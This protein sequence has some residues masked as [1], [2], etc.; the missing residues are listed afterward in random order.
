MNA[1][2]I[3]AGWL[4]QVA[5]R[6]DPQ[7]RLLRAWPLKG[8]ISAQMT[9]LEIQSANGGTRKVIV[10]RPPPWTLERNPRAA[11]DEFRV[12]QL[13]KSLGVA[14]PE[15][16]YVDESRELLSEPYLVIEFIEG[17]PQYTP[18]D[19]KDFVEQMARQLAQI[20]QIKASNPALRSLRQQANRLSDK[21]SQRPGKV[22]A[23]MD[24]GRIRDTLEAV[25]PLPQQNEHVLLHGD[26]WPGNI[27]WEDGQI[28]AV[29]DWEEAEVGDPLADVAISRLDILWLCSREAMHDFTRQYRRLNP[30]DFT[31]LPYWDLIAALRPAGYI[32]EWARWWPEVGRPDIS[33]DSM[34]K[35]HAWFVRQ[36]YEELDRK[37]GKTIDER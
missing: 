7:S 4:E 35:D 1:E 2:L 23:S 30:V 36:A 5:Q 10:R 20:H 17:Q 33:E 28:V 15:P 34:R 26:F 37:S 25:W 32:G 8:G 16:C 22:D 9:A 14:I 21:L 11:R 29:V 13:V 27:L 18:P 3:E 31:K 24:E 19:T 12:L 6:L